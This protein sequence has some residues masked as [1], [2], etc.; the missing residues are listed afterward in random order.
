MTPVLDEVG[1]HIPVV[2][3]GGVGIA[4]RTSSARFA[5]MVED[6]YDGF[7]IQDG[8]AELSF[9]VELFDDNECDDNERGDTKREFESLTSTLEGSFANSHDDLLS[10]DPLSDDPPPDDLAVTYENRIWHIHRGDFDAHWDPLTGRGH[11]RQ[12]INPYALDSV[13]RIVH[14]LVLAQQG[15]FL[16][17]AASA[18]RNGRAFLFSGVSGAGKTTI[19]RL[20]PPDTTLLTDEISYV[21]K[22]ASQISLANGTQQPMPNYRAYGTPFAGELARLGVNCSAPLDTLYMLTQGPENRI[23]DIR[24][25]EATQ[26][27]MRN[28]LFFAHDADLVH[29]VFEAACRFVERVPVRRLTF[30]LDASVWDLIG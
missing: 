21:R 22:N 4:L 29:C 24:P 1:L 23:D 30:R 17:H 16:I 27:L 14:S 28:I 26:M 15:A 6:R 25:A 8:S 11:I 9:D 2:R 3:I 13:L 7:V 10:D 20:A 18:I 12:T 5:S 19:S